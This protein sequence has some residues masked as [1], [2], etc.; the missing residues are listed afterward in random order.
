MITEAV[1]T[2]Q[3]LKISSK[4]NSLTV[5][6]KADSEKILSISA[7]KPDEISDEKVNN[8]VII[9]AIAEL[10]EFCNGERRAFDIA[11]DTTQGT[12]FQQKVWAALRNIPY[13]ETRTYGEIAVE[14]GSP[15]G[16]RAVG[17]ACNKNPHLI[18]TPCHRVVGSTG[19]LTGFACGLEI[20][21][22]LLAIEAIDL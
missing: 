16:A 12:A 1:V 7:A 6:I 10:Q 5:R 11:I 9:K 14:V 3:V 8:P 18:V 21:R 4:S 17:M 19:S 2:L 20:K 22:Q 15:K 13:G